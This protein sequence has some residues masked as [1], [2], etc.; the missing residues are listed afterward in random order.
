MSP[1][2]LVY[3]KIGD[4]FVPLFRVLAL[5]IIITDS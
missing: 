5:L 3:K 1:I 2:P 4:P